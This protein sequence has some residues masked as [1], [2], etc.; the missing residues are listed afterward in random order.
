MSSTPGPG[1]LHRLRW[2]TPDPAAVADRLRRHGIETRD[3]VVAL[4]P[5]TIR[6][7][8]GPADRLAVDDEPRHLDG[9]VVARGWSVLAVAWATVDV[10]RAA[11]ETEAVPG[12]R[13]LRDATLGGS[14]VLVGG[15]P[16]AVALLEPDTEGRLAAMLARHGEGPIGIYALHAAPADAVFRDQGPFGRQRLL[17][18]SSAPWA[19]LVLHVE[20]PRSGVAAAATIRS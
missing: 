18:L 6:L 14:V 20:P 7:V 16:V 8:A 2:T 9:V 3:D 15:L 12:D 1:R 11:A 5:L 19:P 17:A 4:G 10:E 13:R